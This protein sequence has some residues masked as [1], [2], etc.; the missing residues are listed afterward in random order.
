MMGAL[1]AYARVVA[2]ASAV[3]LLTIRPA[4]ALEPWPSQVSAIYRV[5]APVFG[6]I[7]TFQFESKMT[8]KTYTVKGQGQLGGGVGAF[9]WKGTL[10]GSGTVASDTPKPA[11]YSFDYRSYRLFKG[12][13]EGSVRMAFDGTGVTRHVVQPPNHPHPDAVPVKDAHLKDVLDPLTAVMALT[14][15]KG[16]NP[17][18]RSVAVFDGKHR[19][20]LRFEFRKQQR[21][22]EAKPSGQPDL[23]FVCTVRYRPV[24]GHRMNEET[25]AL[26]AETGIEV[27]FRPVPSAHLAIPYKIV[28][29]LPLGTAVLTAVRVD[30][31]TAGQKQIALIY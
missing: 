30:I 16:D 31:V 26:T 4:A 21:I 3:F 2:P 27:T 15:A 22:A 12:T 6:N 10:S 18:G 19:F 29:P 7:G 20:D 11:D 14:R 1:A 5:E 23:G 25:K 17:C 13:K 9:S 28:I 8:G 24:A